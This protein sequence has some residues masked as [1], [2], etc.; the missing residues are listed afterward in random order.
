MAETLTAEQAARRM[1]DIAAHLSVAGLDT[2]LHESRACI[3]VTARTPGP[4][5]EA[6]E[7]CVD[8]D[9]YTEVRYWHPPDAT[10]AQVCT[11]ITRVIAAITAA[12]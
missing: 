9:G 4:V 12:A 7:V 8:E 10:A 3:D 2:S 11:T 1:R 6:V 5:R